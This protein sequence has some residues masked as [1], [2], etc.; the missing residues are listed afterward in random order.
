MLRPDDL[1]SASVHDRDGVAVLAVRG[2]LDMASSAAF[3]CAISEA[4]ADRPQA[5]V[6][7]LSD[8]GFL[9]SAG[10]SVLVEARDRVGDG[11]QFAV[12]TGGPVAG[13][14]I[15]VLELGELLGVHQTVDE[16]LSAVAAH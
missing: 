16:T 8:V 2:E 1:I 4:L 6:I 7:D 12:V 15:E 9:G 10:I 14:T 11:D 13:R 3:K 5:L